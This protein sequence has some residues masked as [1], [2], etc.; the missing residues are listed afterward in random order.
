MISFQVAHLFLVKDNTE[1]YVKVPSEGELG[2]IFIKAVRSCREIRYDYFMKLDENVSLERVLQYHKKMYQT[3]HKKFRQKYPDFI[4]HYILNWE[5]FDTSTSS[6]DLVEQLQD[7]IE[8]RLVKHGRVAMSICVDQHTVTGCFDR[9][10]RC[11]ECFFFFFQ[12]ITTL[13]QM[14]IL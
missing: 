10:V 6:H 4:K 2:C 12:S 9:E 5:M 3:E 14:P 11:A 13:I 8:K 7:R 1:N